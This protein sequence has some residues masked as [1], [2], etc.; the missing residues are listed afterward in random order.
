MQKKI[1]RREREKLQK[2]LSREEYE[3]V[4]EVSI[5]LKEIKAHESGEEIELSNQEAKQRLETEL[6]KKNFK[7]KHEQIY[8]SASAI[9]TYENCSLRTIISSRKASLSFNGKLDFVISNATL[10]GAIWP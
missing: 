10:C 1:K 3:N 4:K 7:P 6:E 5:T 2:A 9:E 8:L